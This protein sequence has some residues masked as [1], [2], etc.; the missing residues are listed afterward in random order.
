MNSEM[1]VLAK[2][3]RKCVEIVGGADALSQK[4]DI[5]RRTLDT[6]LTGQAEPKAFRTLAIANA[7][8]VSVDWLLTGQ[9]EKLSLNEFYDDPEDH[10]VNHRRRDYIPEEWAEFARIPLY[11]TE[12]S[13]ERGV[14]AQVEQGRGSIA[15]SKNW[16]RSKGLHEQHLATITARG[17]SM[18]GTIKNG[19]ILLVNL[20]DTNIGE[21]AIYVIRRDGHLFAKRLQ[22]MFSGELYIK[23]DNPSYTTQVVTLD[24]AS[25]LKILGRVVWIGHEI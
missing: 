14:G 24:K 5:P 18:E 19:D 12:T 6:Y 3:L 4:T 17:D 8:N 2:R 25:D 7:A 13:G 21:D 11:N 15:F 23:S 1:Q 16:L 10:Q 22:L 9:E 20:L